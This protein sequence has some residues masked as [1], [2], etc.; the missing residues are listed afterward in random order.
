MAPYGFR[1]AT[2]SA[3][4]LPWFNVNQITIRM[5]F[6]MI[7]EADDLRVRGVNS[8]SYPVASVETSFDPDAFMT[9]ARFTLATD[10][11][12]KPE[13]LLIELD[14][15]PGGVRTREYGMPLDG[16]RNGVPGDDFV[17]RF[18]V[19]PGAANLG[20]NVNHSD[21]RTVREAL[22]RTIANPGTAVP[23]Y[24]AFSDFDADGRVN[25][26]DLA[27]VRKQLYTYA[28]FTSPT[29]AAGS[30]VVTTTRARPI[31]RGLFSAAPILT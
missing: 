30:D 16:D 2:S 25:F 29:A 27:L 3:R 31:T 7:V 8:A 18:T 1:L 13:N 9:T 15:G 6:D 19:L 26:A 12:S 22:G 5:T 11:F 28:P 23:Y 4:I 24:D 17:F 14:A 21:L 10:G 20:A